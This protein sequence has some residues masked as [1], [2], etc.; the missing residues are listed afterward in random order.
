MDPN[1]EINNRPE[2]Q[3]IKPEDMFQPTVQPGRP[4]PAAQPPV[5]AQPPQSDTSFSA[6]D[7]PGKKKRIIITA[8]GAV[9]LILIIMVVVVILS[10]GGSKPKNNTNQNTQS[11]GILNEPSSLDVENANNSIT[12]D[13][14]S[15]NDDSD[16]PQSNLT[17]INL[18]L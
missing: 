17:D 16:F 7:D 5:Q 8:A 14:T 12:S 13:I 2:P 3:I 4:Q 10:S 11:N 15:L 6:S 18:H 9:V 1:E